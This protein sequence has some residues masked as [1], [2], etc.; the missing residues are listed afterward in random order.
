MA[1]NP[2]GVVIRKV[3]TKS[4]FTR[5]AKKLPPHIY[6]ALQEKLKDLLKEVNVRG[7]RFEK[8]KGY[9]NPDIY[10]FHV[11]GNYKV[12][13]EIDGDEATLRN[14]DVHNEIDRIP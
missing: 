3:H 10:T 11:T 5:R 2:G 1:P 7:L 9:R 14:V 4:K 6:Q 12:S 8:L 13:L